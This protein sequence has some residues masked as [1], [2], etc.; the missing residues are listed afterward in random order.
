MFCTLFFYLF[1]FIQLSFFLHLVIFVFSSWFFFFFQA[2]DG[3]RDLVRSR[4]LGDVYK[5]QNYNS[6]VNPNHQALGLSTDCSTC[7]TPSSDWQP[8]TFPQHNQVYQLLG[9]HA[10][11]ANNCASCHNGNYTTTPDQCVGCHQSDFNSAINPNHTAAGIPT[12]CEQCHTSTNWTPSTF[13]HATTGFT[14][15]G[16]HQSIQ[17][18]SCHEGTTSG[19]NNL[20][21]TCHQPDYNAAPNHTAQSYPT[22]CELCHNSVLWNQTNFDHQNT[23]FPLTGSHTTVTCQQCHSSGYTGT[24]TEC[25]SCHQTAFNNAVNPNHTAAGIP[26]TCESC[27]NSTAWI[28]SSFN[29]TTTGFELLGSHQPLQCSSCHVGTVTG[30]NNQCIACHQPDFNSAPNHVSQSYPTTCELC[31]NSVAW[32]QTS[33]DHQTTQFPLTGAHTTATCQQCHSGGYSGTS[34]LCYTC[35]Q[36]DY[37]QSAN[38][39]HTTL[40]LA[41]TCE[42]C[43]TT[44]PGWAPATFPVHNNFYQLLG[45]HLQVNN[46]TDCHQG[47]YNT[48]PNTCMAVSYT[49]LRAHE[50]VLDLV[51]RLLLEKKKILL[52]EAHTDHLYYKF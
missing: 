40:A 20:C 44:N 23:N 30:L 33:F 42:N 1:Y 48:T 36:N 22:N 16:S 27:H 7:H 8:A 18:S 41:T 11:I 5:R 51:C 21:I 34:T 3:I 43:H 25:F 13:D 6:A 17:C 10:E 47:N 4:G 37:Q 35:H 19:L 28:P 32:D 29:H 38:P 15:L 24:S 31:H 12:T 52:T 49:H 50:T 46:C 2:E 14:L 9:R 45:A 26:S 39:N